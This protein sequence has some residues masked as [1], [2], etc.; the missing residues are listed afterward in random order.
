MDED[1]LTVVE[2]FLMPSEEEEHFSFILGDVLEVHLAQNTY[3]DENLVV[4]TLNV[5]GTIMQLC[6]NQADLEGMAVP[7]MRFLG[8]CWM[9][10]WI[11]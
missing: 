9:Q 8:A 1:F 4:L 11:D 3:T 2:G 7:G 6:I 10:G 5:A